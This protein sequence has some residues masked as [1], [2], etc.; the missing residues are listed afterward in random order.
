MHHAYMCLHFFISQRTL[1]T[2]HHLF[3]TVWLRCS[4]A[5]EIPKSSTASTQA[6][7]CGC[8]YL[9]SREL[10]HLSSFQELIQKQ[11]PAG[12]GRGFSPSLLPVWDPA[13]SSA[14]SSGTSNIR[15][16]LE[17]V[18]RRP[19][20]HSKGWSTSAMGAGWESCGYSAFLFRRGESSW[21]TSEPFPVPKVAT[22]ELGRDFGE[23]DGVIGQGGTSSN[24][25]R[26]GLD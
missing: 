15:E 16:M 6:P 3:I 19:Q 12:P 9:N 26:I 1:I 10:D 14:S 13:W 8:K 23:G 21:Q 20:R 22:R 7:V 11:W 2:Q 4:D 18:Q 24:C 25:K 17:W 5:C